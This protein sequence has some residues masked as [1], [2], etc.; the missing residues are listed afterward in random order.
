MGAGVEL[1]EARSHSCAVLHAQVVYPPVDNQRR[2]LLRPAL[3]P[4]GFRSLLKHN[5]AALDRAS[6]DR[7]I[8]TLGESTHSPLVAPGYGVAGI[9]EAAHRSMMILKHFDSS[10]Y[11]QLLDD[12]A[13]YLESWTPYHQHS[14]WLISGSKWQLGLL[15]VLD[16]LEARGEPLY[17][18]L[19]TVLARYD[20]FDPKRMGKEG[21]ELEQELRKRLEAW[22]ATYR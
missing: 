7:V 13:V 2:A 20:E 16:R 22:R 15:E 6:H 4:G 10:V 5:L 18:S 14:K 21:V 12:F 8:K 9:H 17:G 3:Q 1:D 11:E 19:E